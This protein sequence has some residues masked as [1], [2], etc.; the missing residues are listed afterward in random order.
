MA[1]SAEAF[2]AEGHDLSG[3]EV[4]GGLLAE[5]YSGRGAGGDDVAGVEAHEVAEV[6]DQV[7]DSV[8]HGGGGAVLVAVTVDFEPH[9]EVLGVGDFVG[10]DEPWADGAEGVCGLALDPLAGAFELEGALGEVV[11]DAVAGDVG[12]GVGLGDVAGFL[13]DDDAQFDFPIG[14]EGAAGEDDIVIG[15]A[16]GGGGLHEEEGFGGDCHAGLGG[17]IGVVEADAEEF[18]DAGDAGADA[19][20]AGDDGQ[21]V[22]IDAAE[23]L[24]GIGQEGRA[25]DVGQDVSERADVAFGVEEAGLFVARVAVAQEF[26]DGFLCEGVERVSVPD[27]VG[28][29]LVR[30]EARE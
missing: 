20:V 4:D 13:A 12:E 25:S 15:A 28:V 8:D 10:G 30:D 19:G 24:E 29:I 2:D 16:D 7:G 23:V 11:D 1:L 26:H 17:V 3:A 6:A 9:A 21:G 22:G 27:G 18:A 14:L 5:A